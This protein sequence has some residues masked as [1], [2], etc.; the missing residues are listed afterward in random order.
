MKSTTTRLSVAIFILLPF[1]ISAQSFD[2]TGYWQ[3]DAGGCYQIRQNGNE[4]FW[5]GEPG[6]SVRAQNIFHGASAGNTLVGLW[7][8]LPSNP[9]RAFGT[10]LSIRI[11]SNT[12]M[13]KVS[14][15]VPYR[16]SVW[17]RKNGP[18]NNNN[19]GGQELTPVV[20]AMLKG[21][22]NVKAV[23]DQFGWTLT[24]TNQEGNNF[25]GT[26]SNENAGG[27][28]TNGVLRGNNIEFTRSGYWGTQ[29]WTGILMN[30]GGRL[31]MI[32]GIWTGYVAG[33]YPGRNNWH[34]EKK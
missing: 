19:T 22:W 25:S 13:V 2:L 14:E 27:I 5:T 31:R 3:S 16:G 8:D 21:E 23:N 34:A 20:G 26:F 12:R 28:L 29:Q 7:Y 1:T 10:S 33:D 11:E 17:T 30:D 24:I 15:S 32:N 18:C 4:V 6:G 9:G